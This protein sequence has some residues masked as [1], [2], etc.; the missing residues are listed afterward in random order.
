MPTEEAISAGGNTEFLSFAQVLRDSVACGVIAVDGRRR[1]AVFNPDAETL[2][3]WSAAELLHRP[4]GELPPP[5][6]A[7]LAESLDTGEPVHD[8]EIVLRHVN[9]AEMTA[10]VNTAV[11]AVD[12]QSGVSVVAVLTDLSATGRLEPNLRRL[13]RLASIGTLSAGM[14]HE[15]KNAMV[16]VR[17]FA[18]LLIEKHRD[19]ELAEI[20]SRELDR[21]DG[22]VRQMLRYSAPARASFASVRLHGL[23]EHSLRLLRP[24]LD[25][26]RISLHEDYAAENDRITGDEYQLEQALFNLYF[27]GYE[28]MDPGGELT[29]ATELV[30]APPGAS[31]S[32][33]ALQV[34]VRDT[35]AGIPPQNL[36]RLFETFF[37]T[38]PNGTGLGLPIT[39]RIVQ[40]HGGTISVESRP[41]CGT[42]FKL[43]F[44]LAD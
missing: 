18:E 40:D 4:F 24:Q 21:I 1:V 14:A 44:P 32:G 28:A 37:T 6:P 2:T 10:R 11:S 43:V 38:K 30:P 5:L 23:L 29:V 7:I 33:R 17:T 42:A 3:G 35:G 15:I 9:G 13:D 36:K 39:R 25:A 22:I 26:R 27:N 12:E 41:G 16:A 19:I 20:V 8:R 34:T 31:A